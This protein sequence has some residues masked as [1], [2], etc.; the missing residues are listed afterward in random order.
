MTA[1]P[2]IPLSVLDIAPVMSGSPPARTLRG[3]LDLAK[4][5]EQLGYRRYW[6]A[7]HHNTPNIASS[8]PAVLIAHIANVTSTIRVGSGGVMLPNHPALV[9]AEQFGTL[10]A[11][12]P[13]RIDLGIGRGPGTDPVT[14]KVLRRK[15]DQPAPTEFREQLAELMGYFAQPGAGEPAPA[16]TAVPA[17]DHGLPIWLL[18]T[19]PHSAE[20]AGK[21]GLPFAFAHHINGER[22]VPSLEAYRAAFQPSAHLE[23]P[24]AIVSA[25][26]IAAES[27][28]H[29][30]WLGGPVALSMMQLRPDFQQSTGGTVRFRQD[31]Y[32]SAEDAADYPYTPAQREIVRNYLASKIVGGPDTVRRK[33]A[34]L[35]DRTGADELMALTVVHDHAERVRSYEVLAEAIA[36]DTDTSALLDQVP[37]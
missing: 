26:V 24:Y 22:T 8:A 31:P 33:V 4:R 17:P 36:A 9:V 10:E 15:D 37:R 7:E 25:Q 21:L 32:V 5:T 19:S 16:I 28:A 12:H 11:L 23:R 34:E 20:M 14:A 3:T 27:D 13:G 6:V 1:I 18:G 2:G 35:I 29:A 30:E